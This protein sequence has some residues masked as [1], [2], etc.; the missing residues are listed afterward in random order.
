MRSNIV[1]KS[2]VSVNLVL[3]AIV[4]LR[5]GSSDMGI[6]GKWGGCIPR[7]TKTITAHE[8]L[9]P[10]LKTKKS[11]KHSHLIEICICLYSY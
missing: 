9:Y 3:K 8:N 11:Q 6:D 7:H 2:I 4:P 5:L 1:L 10:R